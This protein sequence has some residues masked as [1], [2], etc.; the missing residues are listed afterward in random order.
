MPDTD[1]SSALERQRWQY[2][3]SRT[4]DR[5]IGAALHIIRAFR[6]CNRFPRR[7]QPYHRR[8]CLTRSTI[9]AAP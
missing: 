1:S 9:I 2:I 6:L 3:A 8:A 4:I 5:P 7:Q